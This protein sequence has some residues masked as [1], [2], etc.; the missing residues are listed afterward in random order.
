MTYTRKKFLKTAVMGLVAGSAMP[1]LAALGQNARGAGPKTEEFTYG[2]ASYSFRKFTLDQVISMTKRAGLTHLT[3]KD[4]HLP[5]K[6]SAAEIKAGVEKV[7][8]AG[9]TPYAGGVIYM[10][11]AEEVNQAFDF[12]R[13]AGF[14]MIVGV[15]DHELLPL[16][17]KKVKEYDVKLAIH[18]HGPGDKVYPS[19]ESVYEKVK[20]LDKRI[21]LCLDIGHVVRI[22]LD[23]IQNAVKYADR[24]Y[25]VH[26]KD[27]TSRTPEG[28]NIEIGRGVIDIPGFLQALRKI[29]YSGVLA[30][31]YEI[32][33][34]DPLPGTAE[35]VGYLKG[36]SRMLA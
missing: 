35:S 19:P 1:P 10:K 27:V 8:A 30:L 21:G 18:N 32:N 12:A 4:M 2:L 33:A 26:I 11:S 24:I 20:G 22:D 31:E 25:D 17:N 15:P 34:D 36:V 5:V 29:R 16:V 14:K 7:R 13:H 23:P 28:T 6:A 9:L 3:L